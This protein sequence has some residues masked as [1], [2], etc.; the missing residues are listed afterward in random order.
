MLDQMMYAERMHQY[1]LHRISLQQP[2]DAPAPQAAT[3]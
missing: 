1:V 3:A 2:Q